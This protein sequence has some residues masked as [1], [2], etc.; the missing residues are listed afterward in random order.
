LLFL[1]TRPIPGMKREKW[2]YMENTY[3]TA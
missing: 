3:F 2:W 1:I